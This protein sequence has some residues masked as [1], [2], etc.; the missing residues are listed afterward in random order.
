[1]DIIH[2]EKLSFEYIRNKAEEFRSQYV[3]PPDKVPVP[4]IEIVELDLQ[5]ESIPIP[6]LLKTIDVDGFLSNDSKSL[7]VDS[8]IYM[9]ER[10]LNRLR[11]TYA[12]EIG[13][14]IL[15][16]DIIKKCNFRNEEE[17][18]HFRE[19][20]SEDDLFIFEQQAYEFAGRLLVP[21]NSL[22]VELQKVTDKIELFKS[23]YPDNNISLYESISRFICKKFAVSDGVILRRLKNEK[24][25][26]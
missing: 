14:F 22:N 4:I 18:L 15:H 3:K 6:N 17:W 23:I 1:M 9:D 8:D 12:H 21:L 24:I 7:Y 26:F 16:Q 10:N 20:M 5:I 25:N 19:D 11:F 13:H 2:P